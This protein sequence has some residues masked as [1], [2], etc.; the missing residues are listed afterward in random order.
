MTR[1]G[2]VIVLM[3]DFSLHLSVGPSGSVG[4]SVETAGNED[5]AVEF[6][7]NVEIRVRRSA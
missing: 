6:D 1:T 5:D 3:A 7:D 2:S 4:G